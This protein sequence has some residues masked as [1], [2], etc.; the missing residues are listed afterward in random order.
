MRVFPRSRGFPGE[1]GRAGSAA[2]RETIESEETFM[3]HLQTRIGRLLPDISK[4]LA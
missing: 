2:R 4:A 1:N 3:V